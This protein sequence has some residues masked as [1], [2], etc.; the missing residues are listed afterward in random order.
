[1]NGCSLDVP[2]SN[3]CVYNKTFGCIP[4]KPMLNK[5]D[6]YTGSG[7]WVKNGCE[8]LFTVNGT[9]IHCGW[10]SRKWKNITCT[11]NQKI[12]HPRISSPMPSRHVCIVIFLCYRSRTQ[13]NANLMDVYNDRI[14]KWKAFNFS[15]FSVD[16]CSL[17]RTFEGITPLNFVGEQGPCVW[18]CV[19]R[20]ETAALKFASSNLPK[21]CKFVIKVSGKYFAPTFLKEFKSIPSST[22]LAIQYKSKRSELFGITRDLLDTYITMPTAKDNEHKLQALSLKKSVCPYV[23]RM[24]PMKLDN[25]TRRSDGVKLLFL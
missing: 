1:M 23:H 7:V 13:T 9:S 25:I 14:P 15:T 11:T 10:R 2:K 21:Q 17:N 3:T 4:E 19:S 24:N 16:A 20:R 5:C 18:S 6:E 22:K 12:V 8:G